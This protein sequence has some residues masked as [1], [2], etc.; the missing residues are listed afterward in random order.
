MHAFV[1]TSS[2]WC[3]C[4]VACLLIIFIMI[5]AHRMFSSAS[6]HLSDA[7]HTKNWEENCA[8]VK[9]WYSVSSSWLVY[10]QLIL[11]C[12]A[13]QA[14]KGRNVWEDYLFSELVWSGWSSPLLEQTT[15]HCLLLGGPYIWPKTKAWWLWYLLKMWLSSCGSVFAQ[16]DH[17][18]PSY[19]GDR[20]YPSSFDRDVY[21]SST[22]NPVFRTHPSSLWYIHQAW[23]KRRK[24]LV[25]NNLQTHLCLSPACCRHHE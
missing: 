15:S 9:T 13:K 3:L 25:N 17:V 5:P 4:P 21:L 23:A 16:S 19:G 8:S 7:F 14:G 12:K 18:W 11:I 6:R 10:L 22:D 2:S 20:V 24:I 1:I